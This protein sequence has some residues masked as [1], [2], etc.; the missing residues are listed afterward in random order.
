[1]EVGPVALDE[2]MREAWASVETEGASRVLETDRVVR[3]DEGRLQQA[4]ENLVRN[5]V[6][7]GVKPGR[8]PS[9]DVAGRT[10]AGG[11]YPTRGDG[12]AGDGSAS[13]WTPFDDSTDGDPPGHDSTGLTVR[14]G[15]LEDGFYVE[16][17]GRGIPEERRA[18]V[19]EP[20]H[21]ATAGGTGFGLATVRRIAEEHGWTL[22]LTEGTDGGARFEFTGVEFER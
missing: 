11:R 13:G 2:V 9:G 4:L 8:S 10:T 19:L 14:M 21:S 22:S 6:E 7:H 5:S 15:D 3:A 12:V 18:A 17:D 20:G 1:M 16:D